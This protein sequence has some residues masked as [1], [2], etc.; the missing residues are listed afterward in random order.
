MPKPVE[1]AVDTY[2]RAWSERDPAVRARMIE[3]C[4]AA[5]GRIVAPNGEIRGR[6]ALADAMAKF[7]ADPE[8][9]RMRVTSAVDARGTIF[10]FR[11][12]TDRRDGTSLQSFDAGEIDAEGRISVLLTFGGP[13]GEASAAPTTATLNA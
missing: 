5:A 13:L 9:V 1:V 12:V 6:A 3:A 4:F 8:I 7:L 11:V 2:I 10:R